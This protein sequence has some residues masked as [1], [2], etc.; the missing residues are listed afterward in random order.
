MYALDNDHDDRSSVSV[1][2]DVDTAAIEMVVRGQWSHRLGT[3]T[4]TRFRKC[5]A[6]HP[7]AIIID[8]QELDDE[9]GASAPLWIAAARAAATLEPPVRLVLS[10]ASATPVAARLRRL[11]AELFL[12]VFDTVTLAHAAIADRLVMTDRLQLRRLSPVPMSVGTARRLVSVACEAWDVPDLLYPARL[13][14]SELVGNAVQHARTDMVVTVRRRDTTLHVSVCDNDPRFPHLRHPREPQ[15][16]PAQSER[17]HGLL[18]VETLSAAWGVIP[19]RTGKMVW[20]T[21]RSYRRTRS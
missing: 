5:L 8:L 14:L 2:W 4:F 19:T 11:G 18:I 12:P 13:V 17:R 15:P 10:M 16:G 21:M 7:A 1:T 6:E 3:D 9:H 20:A